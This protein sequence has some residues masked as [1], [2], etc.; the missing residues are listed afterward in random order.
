MKIITTYL[1]DMVS[2]LLHKEKSTYERDYT[3]WTSRL[4]SGTN[5]TQHN[6]QNKTRRDEMIYGLD[7]QGPLVSLVVGI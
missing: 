1:T 4:F 2:W 7:P 3:R 6:I 5:T